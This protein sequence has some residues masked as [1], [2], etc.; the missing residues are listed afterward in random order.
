MAYTDLDLIYTREQQK[1][2]ADLSADVPVAPAISQKELSLENKRKSLGKGYEKINSSLTPKWIDTSY[3]NGAQ[4][5]FD[6]VHGFNESLGNK[7]VND[8]SSSQY[9]Y[10]LGK[11][12]EELGRQP[13]FDNAGNITHYVGKDSTGN[14]RNYSFEEM[15]K[16][17]YKTFYG[18]ETKQGDSKYG[19][20]SL[21]SDSLPEGS[22]ARY[23]NKFNYDKNAENAVDINKQKMEIAFPK[24]VTDL[25]EKIGH[26]RK[27]AFEERTYLNGRSKEGIRGKEA[28]GSGSTEVYNSDVGFFGDSRDDASFDKEEFFS[29]FMGLAGFQKAPKQD[30]NESSIPLGSIS[31]KY[32]SGGDVSTIST[33][34]GDPGGISYGKYQMSSNAGTMQEFLKSEEGSKFNTFLKDYEIG[35]EGFNQAYSKLA[36]NYKETFEKAQDTFINKTHYQPVKEL[37]E[38]YGI[39]TS[40]PAVKE[41]LFSQSVQHSYKGNKE[42]LEKARNT[43]V[44]AGKSQYTV[45]DLVGAV[46][47]A[48]SDYVSEL[49]LNENVK[50]SILNRYLKESKDVISLSTSNV[51]TQAGEKA[52]ADMSWEE[53]ERERARRNTNEFE[54]TI[55]GGISGLAK[56]AL[57]LADVVQEVATYPLQAIARKITGNENLDIDLIDKE[58]KESIMNTVDDVTGY[59][60]WIDEE[61]VAKMTALIKKSGLDITSWDSFVEAAKDPEKRTLLGDAVYIGLTNP[62]LIATSLTEL[63]GGGGVLGGVTKVGAKVTT[64]VAPKFAEKVGTVFANNKSKIIEDLNKVK[65]NPNI[66]PSVKASVIKEIEDS[67]TLGKKVSDMMKGTSFTNADFMIRMN[68]DIEAYTENNINP[69][70]GEG[71]VP[72]IEKVLS[73]AVLNRIASSAEIGA[74]KLEAKIGTGIT[75]AAKK[76]V[77]K[78]IFDTTKDLVKSGIIEGTQETFDS[79]VEQVNQKLG[80]EAYKDKTF[81]ELLSETTSE[82]LTGT[83]IGVGG[84]VQVSAGSTVLKATPVL[85]D[86]AGSV[87]DKTTGLSKRRVD[88]STATEDTVDFDPVQNAEENLREENLSNESLNTENKENVNLTEEE[89]AKKQEQEARISNIKQMVKENAPA[90]LSSYNESISKI[91]NNV[92]IQNPGDA[93]GAED[94]LVP[95]N[96]DDGYFVQNFEEFGNKDYAFQTEEELK[97]FNYMLAEVST[98]KPIDEKTFNDT[99]KKL[100]GYRKKALNGEL[101]I[102]SVGAGSGRVFGASSSDSVKNYASK[103]AYAEIAGDKTALDTYVQKVTD[104]VTGKDPV[105]YGSSES[106]SSKIKAIVPAVEALVSSGKSTKLIEKTVARNLG[107]SESVV[108]NELRSAIENGKIINKARKTMK[109]VGK[110][111]SSSVKGFMTYFDNA[112]V[113]ISNGSMDK[114]FKDL[115]KLESF[116]ESHAVKLSSM[117][118]AEQ[119]VIDFIEKEVVLRAAGNPDAD[120]KS[121][122]KEIAMELKGND[123]SIGVQVYSYRPGG[124]KAYIKKSEVA[125]MML[126]PESNRYGFYGQMDAVSNELEAME[127]LEGVL[128]DKLSKSSSPDVDLGTSVGS[129]KEAPEKATNSKSVESTEKADK[130]PT[131]TDSTE[132]NVTENLGKEP[133]EAKA[134]KAEPS[135]KEEKTETV[136]RSSEKVEATL[137][138]EENTKTTDATE[139]KTTEPKVKGTETKNVET[140]SNQVDKKQETSEVTTKEEVSQADGKTSTR[141]EL[142]KTN[143]V[144]SETKKEVKSISK[145]IEDKLV[146]RYSITKDKYLSEEMRELLTDQID[147]EVEYLADSKKELLEKLSGNKNTFKEKVLSNMNNKKGKSVA[148]FKA[149]QNKKGSIEDKALRNID[150]LFTV[151]NTTGLTSYDEATAKALDPNFDA[152]VNAITRSIK[153]FSKADNDAETDIARL[154]LFNENGSLN[155][156]AVVAMDIAIVK[157]LEE[158]GRDIGV[159]KTKEDLASMFGI[160][161]ESVT[162]GLLNKFKRG[163]MV[164]RYAAEELGKRIIK[165]LGLKAKDPKAEEALVSSFGAITLLVLENKGVIDKFSGQ[166]EDTTMPLSLLEPDPLK[167]SQRTGSVR[168]IRYSTNSHIFRDMPF[169]KKDS[170][171]YS[172][173]Y[174]IEDVNEKTYS[175]IP[176]KPNYDRKVHKKKYMNQT[177]VHQEASN[178]L[179][180]TEFKFNSGWDVLKEKFP[181]VESLVNHM[182]KDMPKADKDGNQIG[183]SMTKDSFDSLVA[184]MDAMEADIL[185]LYRAADDLKAG[186][187][188]NTG[189]F[190]KWFVAK[191]HRFHLDSNTVNPQSEKNF[192]RWLLTEKT[193]TTL[194]KEDVINTLKGESPKEETAVGFAYG[195]VQAFDGNDGVP[196]ID[197]DNESKILEKAL[198][199]LSM[200]EKDLVDM[201]MNADHIG[202]GLLAV[203]NIKKFQ[204]GGKTFESDM[205]AEYDG[206]TNGFAFR[207]MQFPV[208]GDSWFTKIG[209]I[210]KETFGD[211]EGYYDGFSN[212][213][214]A[215]D[216]GVEDVYISVGAEYA[217]NASDAVDAVIN[218][219]N[220]VSIKLLNTLKKYEL[221]TDPNDKGAIRKIMKAPVMVFNYAAGIKGIIDS[222]V[223]EA[224]LKTLDSLI[225]KDANGKYIISDN[226]LNSILPRMASFRAK[227]STT[228]IE[229]PSMKPLKSAIETLYNDL[230]SIPMENTLN[231]LFGDQI[232]VNNFIVKGTEIAYT[233]FKARYDLWYKN[234]QEATRAE[235]EAFI[236]EN[237]ENAP[238]LKGPKSLSENDKLVFLDYVQDNDGKAENVNTY[239]RSGGFLPTKVVSEKLKAPG[240]SP[241]VLSIISLD[242]SVLADSINGSSSGFLPVHDAMVVNVEQMNDVKNYNK[243]FYTTNRDYSIFQEMLN[244]VEYTIEET[245]KY[246]SNP[247]NADNQIV[248]GDMML[249]GEK[250]SVEEFMNSFNDLNNTIQIKRDELFSYDAKIGQMG[251]SDTSMYE[252]NNNTRENEQND[253]A[254]SIMKELKS[255]FH[256]DK[257]IKEE[258]K[259][260]NK[261]LK[262]KGC[263]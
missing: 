219:S 23:G 252:V 64:K 73:M 163:G 124:E 185:E 246:N 236:L 86:L 220:Q 227:L 217:Q 258:N 201:A 172:D 43:L 34:A 14:L 6:N 42:I 71:D 114:V 190:F 16:D 18:Y 216:L 41:M 107:V 28:F 215:R 126:N 39:D 211:L 168:L 142:K 214:Q 253:V 154:V 30:T 99:Y 195:L 138:N 69:E 49:D 103:I 12:T 44:E 231:T 235:R 251:G 72:S 247:D 208:S 95:E 20:S 237:L 263:K 146:E 188:D 205:V 171:D 85:K 65:S 13:S 1:Q 200:D 250:V 21:Y 180:S 66:T 53:K 159:A 224:V 199:L 29:E 118:K 218:G 245:N 170:E 70:T 128:V 87:I 178:K 61:D 151:G 186:T 230:Y 156:H 209:F 223:S 166:K 174:S 248:F 5:V 260:M 213:N 212:M 2:I 192:T 75:E 79:I 48:R 24:N 80:S 153:R 129:K 82:I 92:K 15:E 198:E 189:I 77:T 229:D 255:I 173:A 27:E 33:G 187:R 121:I 89:L 137:K 242:S 83:I 35:S 182:T 256:N 116:K 243:S 184:K 203:A 56:G 140:K 249:D 52:F 45:D 119:E 150:D 102:A 262:D 46:Y 108:A 3:D 110:E 225:E 36:T 7:Y 97:L 181:T 105:V 228:S 122:L 257:R 9:Q 194:N 164:H 152:T 26:G 54:Q 109:V 17:G 232:Q 10:L 204:K 40:S 136:N 81:K 206:L 239:K 193:V 176:P 104:I 233:A 141:E 63:A 68:N 238:G 117:K 132:S 161:E 25:L 125:F 96:G 113:N 112:Q 62:S 143:K 90:V 133:T 60:R 94:M 183:N 115:D 101:D 130:N 222:M 11:A 98:E 226:E 127:N 197:K 135:S 261:I 55:S 106:Y 76:G 259:K 241:A 51:Q 157:F 148:L 162:L 202:H 234:N 91:K 155:A 244:V 57:E 32:E 177:V 144:I 167:A 175:K 4:G 88:T 169:I 19:V 207:T 179:E 191:N 50:N 240:V 93:I 37:A 158:S 67:Y 134:E 111:A 254:E 120:R 139:T 123:S 31:S 78:A 59:E 221:I 100:G 84:G 196:A 38:S 8:L 22:D 74:F 165:E 145:K 149:I 160:P 58:A 210:S 131:I 47:D 147:L